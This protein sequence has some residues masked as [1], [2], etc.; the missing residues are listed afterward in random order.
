VTPALGDLPPP[1]LPDMPPWWGT[2]L[3]ALGVVVFLFEVWLRVT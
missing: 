3:G 2:A 1:R